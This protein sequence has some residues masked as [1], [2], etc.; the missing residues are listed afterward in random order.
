MSKGIRQSSY[1]KYLPAIYQTQGKGPSS[2]LLGRILLAFEAIVSGL[3]QGDYPQ[4]MERV[5][6][7]EEILDHIHDYLDPDPFHPG[8]TD[9]TPSE[10]LP[11]LA[12]WVA[13][14]LK[15]GKEWDDEKNRS[16]ISSIVRLYKK[17]GTKEGLT[18]Y[19]KIYVG[20]DIKFYINEF[21]EPCRV[22]ITST[23]GTNT[24]IG[25][26]RPYYFEIHMVLP[27]PDPGLLEQKKQALYEIIDQEKP[28]HTYY[29][30]TIQVPTMRI[31]EYSTVGADTLI[32]GMI[33]KT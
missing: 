5:R 11:W 9:R 23:V 20:R 15:K 29:G 31:G 26:G 25:H 6:G 10:F 2:G 17:R 19:L 30:L 7:I 24:I 33:D 13:L 14:V 18:E 12:S 1:L 21:I 3:P 22:G 4:G 28:A 8:N 27:V 32:G 16:L